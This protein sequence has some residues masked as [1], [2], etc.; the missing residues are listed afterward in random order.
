MDNQLGSVS[1]QQIFQGWEFSSELALENF[2]WSRLEFLL[3]L[4]LVHRQM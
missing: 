1:L 2:V 4:K 3:Q